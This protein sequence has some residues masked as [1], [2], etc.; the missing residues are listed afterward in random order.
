MVENREFAGNPPACSDAGMEAKHTYEQ[1]FS[2]YL[3][4][5]VRKDKT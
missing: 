1:R 3:S 5:A 2:S 4:E